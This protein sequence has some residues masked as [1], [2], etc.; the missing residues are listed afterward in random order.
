[1]LIENGVWKGYDCSDLQ[2]G[3]LEIPQQVQKIDLRSIHKY[4]YKYFGG[5]KRYG[6]QVDPQNPVYYSEG[7]CMIER[8]TGKI[9]FGTAKSTLPQNGSIRSIG[10]GAFAWCDFGDRN[11]DVPGS[12]E[13]VEEYAFYGAWHIRE[14]RF[15]PG[16]CRIGDFALAAMQTER[17]FFSET[18]ERIGFCDLPETVVQIIVD[19]KNP[20]F[21]V[22]SGCLIREQDKTVLA[23]TGQTVQIPDG[24]KAI[25][26][27]AC[28]KGLSPTRI[29]V[30]PDSVTQIENDVMPNSLLGLMY[31]NIFR[32]SK[33]QKLRERKNF[34]ADSSFCPTLSVAIIKAHEDSCA[35]EYARKHGIAHLYLEDE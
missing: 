20:L 34:Y 33:K 31:G 28:M 35:I 19:E 9:V 22:R 15:L 1:M 7:N 21:S 16:V 32:K 27:F 10:V 14:L 6:L 24:I 30:I 29:V 12:V 8:K 17:V 5:G 13:T 2:N 26:P 3:I 23:V 25:A 18:V 4:M 11:I